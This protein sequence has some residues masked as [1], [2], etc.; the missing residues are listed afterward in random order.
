MAFPTGVIEIRKC[1]DEELK[2][3]LDEAR[4]ASKHSRKLGRVKEF[5]AY[6]K[7]ATWRRMNGFDRIVKGEE[8]WSHVYRSLPPTPEQYTA[9]LWSEVNALKNAISM[10]TED[11]VTRPRQK[12]SVDE[13]LANFEFARIKAYAEKRSRDEATQVQVTVTQV[14]TVQHASPY[15][16]DLEPSPDVC[17]KL[18][19]TEAGKM[20][21]ELEELESPSAGTILETPGQ[22]CPPNEGIW[23]QGR[24]TACG[25]LTAGVDSSQK[26]IIS[27]PTT[28]SVDKRVKDTTMVA[29]ISSK[30]ATRQNEG[31]RHS[32]NR[33]SSSTP[34]G[35]ERTHRLGTRL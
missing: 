7:L 9:S 11:T 16:L 18:E 3:M 5:L 6:Q 22:Q 26:E 17:V 31:T 25:I 13:M 28:E 19:N 15:P 21:P 27:S 14:N 33:T 1:S 10:P 30:V 23:E 35:E 2:T 8:N 4:E 34:V 20:G 29:D 24:T 12:D 32:A